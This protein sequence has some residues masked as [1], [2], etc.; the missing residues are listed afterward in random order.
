MSPNLLENV[1]KGTWSSAG[2]SLPPFWRPGV[3]TDWRVSDHGCEGEGG[4]IPR[5]S[6]DSRE[7][8]ET[9]VLCD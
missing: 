1:Q 6:A 2:D 8:A 3:W 4:R 5:E 9:R 7:F